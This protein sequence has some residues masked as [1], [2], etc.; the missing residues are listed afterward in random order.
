MGERA[1]ILLY[2]KK[3]IF[4]SSIPFSRGIVAPITQYFDFWEILVAWFLENILAL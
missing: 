3:P 2:Q 4:T 1:R